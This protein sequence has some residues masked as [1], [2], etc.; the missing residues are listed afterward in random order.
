MD[1][2]L[3]FNE[4]EALAAYRVRLYQVDSLANLVQQLNK[5]AQPSSNPTA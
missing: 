3:S 4:P 1:N 2:R 5:T